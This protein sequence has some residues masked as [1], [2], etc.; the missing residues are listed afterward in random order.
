MLCSNLAIALKSWQL[1]MIIDILQVL[2]C[3]VKPII[4]LTLFLYFGH[5][6]NLDFIENIVRNRYG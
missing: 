1:G 4:N 6:Y 2:I 5:G 3:L